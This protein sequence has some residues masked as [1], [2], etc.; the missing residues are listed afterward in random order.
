MDTNSS[1]TEKALPVIGPQ[2]FREILN[3]P[4]FAREFFFPLSI[5]SWEDDRFHL[6]I[7]ELERAG[8]GISGVRLHA[9]EGA[10]QE[11]IRDCQTDMKNLIRSVIQLRQAPELC[12][13]VLSAE[14]FVHAPLLGNFSGTR[15]KFGL[16]CPR[17]RRFRDDDSAAA[18]CHKQIVRTVHWSGFLVAK[19]RD[20]Q[21]H[22]G[23]R[24]LLDWAGNLELRLSRSRRKGDLMADIKSWT[25]HLSWLILKR[26]AVKW[27]YHDGPR[28]A[29]TLAFY[30]VFSAMPLLFLAISVVSASSL[31]KQSDA[32]S[33]THTLLEKVFDKEAADLV[34]D[35]HSGIT[36]PSGF[37]GIT[38]GLVLFLY[39]SSSVFLEAQSSLCM[40][41]RLNPPTAIT[42]LRV[43]RR[44]GEAIALVTIFA[45]LLTGSLILHALLPVF[46]DALLSFLFVTMLLATT[47][48]ILSSNRIEWEYTWY[49]AIITALLL[50]LGR[51]IISRFLLNF[52]VRTAYGEAGVVMILMLWVYYSAQVFYFGAELI[53]ARR[54][55][56]EWMEPQA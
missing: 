34:T 27:W 7:N 43:V 23:F 11:I 29:A 24:G 17:D 8:S 28:L 40:I 48:R 20:F 31:V 39:A 16:Y 44:Y 4:D 41:W 36:K 50:L 33:Q 14:P 42:W 26:A 19:S 22:T 53:E 51:V 46:V 38:I 2:R 6:G 3:T 10:S 21:P 55:R 18:E 13:A 15:V 35:V 12:G 56:F 9:R 5:A 52:P 47:Y 30:A 32:L 49:G 25:P 45:L 54:S 1:L 37:W